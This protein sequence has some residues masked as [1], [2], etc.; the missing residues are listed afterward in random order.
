MSIWG[1]RP[2]PE[3]PVPFRINRMDAIIAAYKRDVD[4]TLIRENLRL[5]PEQRLRELMELLRAAD[6]FARAGKALRRNQ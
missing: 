2:L 6:E 4:R 1:M 3:G 5:T